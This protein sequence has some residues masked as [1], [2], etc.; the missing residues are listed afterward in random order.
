MK[1]R[2]GPLILQLLALVLLSS[3][4]ARAEVPFPVEPY[5]YPFR[6]VAGSGNVSSL[7]FNPALL[8]LQDEVEFGWYH[9]FSGNPTGFNS[10]ALRAKAV[11]FSISWLD[12]PVFGKRREYLMGFGRRLSKVVI[13]GATF[14]W[15]KADSPLLQNKTIW[16]FGGALTP[17]P[18]FSIGFRWENAF[19]TKVNDEST[20]GLFVLGVRTEPAGPRLAVSLDLFYPQSGTS[21]DADFRLAAQ[22]RPSP[23]LSVMA[24]V[25]TEERVGIELRFAVERNAGG[26][27]L[28][29]IDYTDYQDGTFY[30]TVRNGE[31]P[32]S[33]RRTP[34]R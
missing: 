29:M 22:V 6:S 19:H 5:P 18:A 24:F 7:R 31:Y 26:A 15:L 12:D 28:R 10:F 4:V 14:R 25:D 3:W 32:H 13:V 34:E 2:L 9:K 16:T 27:E 8:G 11:A 23:G 20:D 30:T 21:E 1:L 17:S 33:R